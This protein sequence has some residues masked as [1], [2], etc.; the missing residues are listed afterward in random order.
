M[1]RVWTSPF[2]ALLAPGCVTSFAP[3]SH[4]LSKLPPDDA[5]AETIDVL[6]QMYAFTEHKGID[7]AEL[8]V[9][10]GEEVAGWGQDDPE[11]DHVL[12]ALVLELPDGHVLL[13][14]AEPDRQRCPQAAASLGVTFGDLDDSSIVVV[15]VD[16]SGPAAEAGLAPGDE[17]QMWAGLSVTEA[18]AMQPVHCWHDGLATI[19]RR[20]QARLRFLGRAEEGAEV[21]MQITRDGQ[22]WGTTVTA[23]PDPRPWAEVLGA[24]EPD[25]R[26]TA[27][28]WT[29][30]VG[31][32]AIGWEAT[33]ATDRDVRRELSNLWADGARALIVDLRGNDG[34]TDQTASNVLGMFT[35]RSWFYETI[36]MFDRRRDD[37]RAVSE[38]W[39]EPQEVRWDLPAAVLIDGE[40][41]SSGEGMAMMFAQFP[42][43]EVVGF[44]A[45]NGSFGSGGST[46]QL[47]GDW[48]L[49]FPAGRS[50]D[51]DGEIQIDSDHTLQGGIAPT[52]RVPR[53]RANRLARGAD[54]HGFLV[55]YAIANVLEAP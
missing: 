13:R 3:V 9:R 37:Q 5:L 11:Y 45:T 18:L 19:E 2:A 4:D 43:I 50:L 24:A 34:G 54:P 46:I 53:S 14:N 8:R 51:A 20:D 41:V 55:D 42:G 17:L 49:T 29:K 44:D 26:V 6:E 36:T 39:V 12:R 16:E 22:T 52:H 23:Q 10:L 25:A 1:W 30:D 48:E 15:A 47:P 32:L 38:V 28:M 35:D 21:S 33:A 27:R 40:T 7:W 31:Y